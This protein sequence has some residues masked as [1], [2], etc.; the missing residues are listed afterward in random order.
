MNVNQKHLNRARSYLSQA[1]G[2]IH[3]TQTAAN[4]IDNTD[5]GLDTV[6]GGADL[7]IGAVEE[8]KVFLNK[9]IDEL[10]GIK[11]DG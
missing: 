3:V 6:K 7:A 5:E 1:M 8:A 11:G 9:T 4:M 2:I 10:K